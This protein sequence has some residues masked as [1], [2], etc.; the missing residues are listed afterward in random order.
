MRLVFMGTPAFAVPALEALAKAHDIRLVITR[1]DRPRRRSGGPPEPSDVKAAARPLGLDV[2]EPPTLRDPAVVERLLAATPDAIVVVAF[3]LL[4]PE[5]V[6]AVPRLGSV[7]LH[8]SLL[9]RWR[10]A[11]PVARAILAGDTRTGVTT[12]RMERGLDTGPT[13]LSR[14]CDIDPE[15]TAGALT[16]R[17]AALGA[18]LLLETIAGLD[19]GTVTP[20]PQDEALATWAPPLSRADARLDWNETAASLAFRVRATQPWPI[21]EAMLNGRRVQILAAA[22]EP[23]VPAPVDQGAG[24][25]EEPASG[26]VVAAGAALRVACGGRSLLRVSRLRVAGGRAIGARDAVNGR[27]VAPG[28]RFTSIP[29]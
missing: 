16:A 26:T 25:Q 6:L 7:N 19:A 21:A 2:A 17:L 28:D 11:A 29:T 10:G 9:P 27:L 1:P 3:G 13:L 8:A 22:A 24:S 5:P 15:E 14:A 4:L 12:M 23:A 18:P 20:T